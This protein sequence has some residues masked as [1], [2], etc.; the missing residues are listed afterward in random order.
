MGFL[1]KL[2]VVALVVI[3]VLVFWRWL[4][5]NERREQAARHDRAQ[6]NMA[7]ARQAAGDARGEKVPFWRRARTPDPQKPATIPVEDMAACSV[8]GAFV[9]PN[10]PRCSRA[11]CPR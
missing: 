6:H 7:G 1:G 4:T 3:G 5:R 11:D 9:A 8:C 10:A 2:I